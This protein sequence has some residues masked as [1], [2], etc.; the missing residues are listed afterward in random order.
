LHRPGALYASTGSRRRKQGQKTRSLP[1]AVETF[2]K[3]LQ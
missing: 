1:V 2:L 3:G